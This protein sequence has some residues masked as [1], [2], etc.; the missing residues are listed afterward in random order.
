M[1]LKTLPQFKALVTQD[2]QLASSRT[3]RVGIMTLFFFMKRNIG[4]RFRALSSC[5]ILIIIFVML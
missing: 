1:D 4:G 5:P 2:D 3:K